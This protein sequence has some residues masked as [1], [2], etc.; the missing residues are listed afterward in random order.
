MEEAEA[1]SFVAN[2]MATKQ[3]DQKAGIQEEKNKEAQS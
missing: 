1:C 2:Q 3:H